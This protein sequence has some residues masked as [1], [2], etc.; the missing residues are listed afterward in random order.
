MRLSH[1]SCGWPAA[2]VLMLS[3]YILH[4]GVDRALAQEAVD[5][6]EMGGRGQ[7]SDLKSPAGQHLDTNGRAAQPKGRKVRKPVQR[8]SGGS[9]RSGRAQDRE[10]S[11]TAGREPQD[12]APSDSSS[13]NLFFPD[14]QAP[15]LDFSIRPILAFAWDTVR[16][17][18]QGPD[19]SQRDVGYDTLTM[20]GGLRLGVQNM[21]LVTGN[22]GLE[23]SPYVGYAYGQRVVQSND[24]DISDWTYH[25]IMLGETTAV[26]IRMVRYE[27]GLHF[28][29]IFGSGTGFTPSSQLEVVQDLGLKTTQNT[30]IHTTLTVGRLF[31]ESVAAYLQ[32]YTDIW[33][34]VRWN[35]FLSVRVDLGPGQDFIWFPTSELSFSNTY[36]RAL[37]SWD[38]F[39]S[40]GVA[41][42]M[43]YEIASEVDVS[44]TRGGQVNLGAGVREPL[45]DLGSGVSRL[46]R[47]EDSA[48]VVLFAGLRDV[49]FGVS[50]GYISRFDVQNTFERAGAR[51]VQT[52]QGLGVY[53]GLQ[54]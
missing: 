20:E 49:F 12:S 8:K 54:I 23:V 5:G 7:P 43:Q 4:L 25:R 24:M 32:Q 41:G 45:Q 46:G 37:L 28:G 36:A 21:P 1:L 2:T 17:S 29:R 15:S 9:R 42:S 13:E 27:L 33:L 16:V 11:G 6:E 35:P 40:F 14:W 3:F 19:G 48:S 30:S 39:A 53:V 26:R 22:P 51:E 31:E 47:E 34:H 10:A 50:V 44:G 18:A 38:I 52:T